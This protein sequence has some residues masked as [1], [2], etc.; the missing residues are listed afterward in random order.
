MQDQADTDDDCYAEILNDDII[1]LDEE[2]LKAS[3]AFRPNNPTQQ[4]TILS[5]ASSS[6][7]S[8]CGIKKESNQTMNCYA[9]FRIKNVDAGDTASSSGWR[10]PNPF[11]TKKDDDSQRLMKNVMATTA[12]LAVLISVFFTVLTTRD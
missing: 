3:Q 1:K 12:F 7:R 6:R 5:E 4:E 8:E 9:L 11:H 10:I 2:A